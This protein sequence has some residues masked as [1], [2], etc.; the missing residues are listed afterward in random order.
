LTRRTPHPILI[1]K[2]RHFSAALRDHCKHRVNK[3]IAEILMPLDEVRQAL[4]RGFM[5]VWV[6]A[7]LFEVTQD[8]A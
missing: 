4:R 5:T 1:Q 2:Q 7:E 8:F 3:R 6:L